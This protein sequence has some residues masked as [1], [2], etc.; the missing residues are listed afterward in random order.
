MPCPIQGQPSSL[1]PLSPTSTLYTDRASLVPDFCLIPHLLELWT[2][3]PPY[4]LH[5]CLS[6][7]SIVLE[8]GRW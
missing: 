1:P 4:S 2:P 6:P 3:K 5:P 8:G 7:A